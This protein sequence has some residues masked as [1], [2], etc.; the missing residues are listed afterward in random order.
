MTLRLR[1]ADLAW[2]DETRAAMVVEDAV[3]PCSPADPRATSGS[4]A[5]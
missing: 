5:R 3:H 4:P 1:T 2:W